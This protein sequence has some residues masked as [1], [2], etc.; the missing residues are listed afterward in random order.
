MVCALV[1]ER[2]TNNNTQRKIKTMNNLMFNRIIASTTIENSLCVS[3]KITLEKKISRITLKKQS[4][5]MQWKKIAQFTK[6]DDGRKKKHSWLV[7]AFAKCVCCLEECRSLSHSCRK[8]RCTSIITN[9]LK[10]AQARAKKIQQRT[11][12]R[13]PNKVNFLCAFSPVHPTTTRAKKKL[14]YNSVVSA[15]LF[16]LF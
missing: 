16:H 10:Q 14:M 7:V 9:N 5:E 12:T 11:Y 4:I 1:N 3:N 6:N 13:N 15:L 2:K 8:M